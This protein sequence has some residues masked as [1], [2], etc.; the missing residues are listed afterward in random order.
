[1]IKPFEVLTLVISCDCQLEYLLE[2]PR[3]T[4]LNDVISKNCDWTERLSL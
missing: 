2:S 1:M 4:K 3:Q